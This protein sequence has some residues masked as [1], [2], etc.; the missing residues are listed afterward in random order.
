MQTLHIHLQGDRG[1]I[2]YKQQ[3]QLLAWKFIL[4]YTALPQVSKGYTQLNGHMNR[5]RSDILTPIFPDF[6]RPKKFNIVQ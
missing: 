2:S 1:K 4:S 3:S 5:V 6:L